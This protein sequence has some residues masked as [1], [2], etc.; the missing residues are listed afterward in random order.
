MSGALPD[1]ITDWLEQELQ[2]ALARQPDDHHR[3][4]LLTQQWNVWAERRRQF[5]EDGKLFTHPH[6]GSMQLID[7]LIVLCMI[8]GAKSKLERVPA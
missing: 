8:D 3:Y 2:K 1:T 4:R 6:Y 7:Y 5:A